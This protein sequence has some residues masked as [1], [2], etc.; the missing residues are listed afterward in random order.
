[1]SRSIS[2]ARSSAEAILEFGFE[3][4]CIAT[5]ARWRRDG[6]SRQ[7]VVPIPIDAA[8]PLFT[9]DDIMEGRLPSGRVAAL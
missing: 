3:H 9:P 4:V 6:V 7:H 1:M 5:G 2:T 8:M